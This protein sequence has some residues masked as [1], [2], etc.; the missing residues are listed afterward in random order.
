M[1]IMALEKAPV[2]PNDLTRDFSCFTA[3]QQVVTI[4]Q[5][6]DDL[7]G[8]NSAAKY[9]GEKSTKPGLRA[10]GWDW[11]GVA[12]PDE[13]QLSDD[14]SCG[15]AGAGIELLGCLEGASRDKT[16]RHS[17]KVCLLQDEAGAGQG[18]TGPHY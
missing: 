1:V 16:T 12:R 9:L 17:V 7:I 3:S 10:P 2:S 5:N 11:T 15:C 4:L 8:N 14:A 18:R 13:T 6:C